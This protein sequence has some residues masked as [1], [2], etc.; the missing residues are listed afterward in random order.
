MANLNLT[1]NEQVKLTVKY[2]GTTVTISDGTATFSENVTSRNMTLDTI[3]AY[4]A[5]TMTD[6]TLFNMKIWSGG[7]RNT[8]TLVLD[9]EAINEKF[10]DKSGNH[11][12]T[13]YD[14]GGAGDGITF[15][16]SDEGI[17]DYYAT[18]EDE[19]FTKNPIVENSFKLQK[20]TDTLVNSL[21]A[22]YYYNNDTSN[23][24]T[25]ETF[26][27]TTLPTTIESTYELTKISDPDTVDKLKDVVFDT[28]GFRAYECSFQTISSSMIHEIFD[29]I[30]IRHPL[31]QN[32][33]TDMTSKKW[34]ITSVEVDTESMLTTITAVELI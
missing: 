1:S 21:I 29:I 18:T 30:N 14:A 34:I 25:Q 23:S 7:D 8:G 16:L 6:G 32:L 3:M 33:F 5:N 31:L 2:D 15:E 26:T 28:K 19:E 22:N 11:Y 27:D 10:V 4:D 12:F 20:S 9:L 17:Y 24:Q 13:E